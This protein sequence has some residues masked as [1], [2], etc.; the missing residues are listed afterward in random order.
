MR[1][2]DHIH[3]AT[4]R[5]AKTRCGELPVCRVSYTKIHRARFQ[6]EIGLGV[7]SCGVSKSVDDFPKLSPKDTGHNDLEELPTTTRHAS[8]IYRESLKPAENKRAPPTTRGSMSW[9]RLLVDGARRAIFA[10]LRDGFHEMRID[11]RIFRRIAND[12][13]WVLALPC[14][15]HLAKHHFAE[16]DDATIG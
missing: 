13:Q 12:A 10:D 2:K 16:H 15:L 14:F 11:Q 9:G 1:L 6:T 8:G 7:A 4:L 5:Q 3:D